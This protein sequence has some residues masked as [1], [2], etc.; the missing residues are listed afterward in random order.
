MCRRVEVE[1]E[2]KGMVVGV[3]GRVV[4]VPPPADRQ[5]RQFHLAL[6]MLSSDEQRVAIY[7]EFVIYAYC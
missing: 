3:S 6:N 4:A 5:I 1:G 7:G 2:E